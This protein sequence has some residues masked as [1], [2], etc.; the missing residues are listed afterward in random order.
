MSL[1]IG[2]LENTY[3]DQRYHMTS[4]ISLF[5]WKSSLHF[6]VMISKNLKIALF[7]PKLSQLLNILRPALPL[8]F[9]QI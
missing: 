9:K 4:Y 6:A 5:H 8:V 2:I 1:C 3:P 7:Q